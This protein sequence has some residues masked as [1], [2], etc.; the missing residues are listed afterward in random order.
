MTFSAEN[1]ERPSVDLQMIVDQKGDEFES[2]WLAGKQP[3]IEEFISELESPVRELALRELILLEL[4]L[5]GRSA[6]AAD[7]MARFPE[8]SG[9][10]QECF[11]ISTEVGSSVRSNLSSSR[12]SLPGGRIL[13]DYE[14]I[15]QIGA[16]GMGQVYQARHL[17]MKR[18]V[19]LKTLPSSLM[20]SIELQKRFQREVEA[21][22]QLDHPNIVSAYDAGEADNVH[23]LVMQYVDGQD[24]MSLLNERQ[25]LEPHV[26]VD[27]II[28]AG[29]GLQFAH[30]HGVIHRDV[31]PSNLLVD[32]AGTVKILDMGL[33]RFDQPHD[34]DREQ[35]SELTQQGSVMGTADYI[36]PEQSL[37]ARKADHRSDIYSLGCTL[38]HLLTGRPVFS[39]ST[40]Q[41][42][43]FRHHRDPIPLASQFA[44]GLPS[45]LDRVLSK[46]LAKNPENRFQTMDDVLRALESLGNLE[47]LKIEYPSF[48][49][50]VDQADLN[51]RN[52]LVENT[53]H[54]FELPSTIVE[55]PQWTGKELALG[56]SL[57]SIL[58]VASLV[59]VT[60]AYTTWTSEL[61][62]NHYEKLTGTYVSGLGWEI[63]CLRAIIYLPS[64]I[65][66]CC[67]RFKTEMLQIVGVLPSRRIVIVAR[68]LLVVFSVGF[69]ILETHRHLSVDQAPTQLVE[70]TGGD[71]SD[72]VLVAKQQRPYAAYLP[73]SLINYMVVMP[74]L[75]I[76]PIAALGADLP[77]LRG[78][79]R[80]LAAAFKRED[81]SE[82]QILSGF[83]KFELN[84]QAICAR[85][86]DFLLLL[87][88]AINFECWLGRFTLSETAFRL[89]TG[90]WM[91]VALITV[92]SFIWFFA[93]YTDSN[94][95]AS[96]AL[97]NR[98]S[99]QSVNFRNQHNSAAFLKWL[100][101]G[102]L[103]GLGV[104]VSMLVLL[105][106]LLAN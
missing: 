54:H 69:G 65:L 41:E 30:Q 92:G 71:V 11:A 98:E 85:Y 86:L 96:R 82:Q 31:K 53:P 52:S 68:I 91:I 40:I 43:I 83:Q 47:D 55:P 93:I 42:K 87:L 26:A 46:M 63:E 22:A 66:L 7:F 17:R 4:E 105:L 29:R 75:V 27:S 61:W 79:Q 106:W 51:T 49:Q 73:Y 38:Y 100:I 95:A 5:G 23:Y 45:E 6:S 18:T 104:T 1:P 10:V 44:N 99:T 62:L 74:L 64:V 76:V 32:R 57:V 35:V 21:V 60:L 15:K 67:W 88:I 80:N 9:V 78:Q 56:L 16:G 34:G 33:A 24:L 97:V 103:S 81:L 102:R 39:G 94:Q 19:A 28:Q 90:G 14:I 84:C 89:M 77:Q 20:D 101:T 58:L 72:Q 8:H 59:S 50:D 70:E 12:N 25:Y 37:D 13:G 36:S 3:M 48:K 2:K